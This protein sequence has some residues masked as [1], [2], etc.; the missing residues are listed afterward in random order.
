MEDGSVAV[1]EAA[2]SA[3][4]LPQAESDEEGGMSSDSEAPIVTQTRVG[5]VSRKPKWRLDRGEE[6]DVQQQQKK[7]RAKKAQQGKGSGA[8]TKKVGKRS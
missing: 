3:H 4:I 1:S 6:D 2:L 5:R 8:P 7:K